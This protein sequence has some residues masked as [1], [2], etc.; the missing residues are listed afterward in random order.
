MSKRINFRNGISSAL[1][2]SVISAA[3]IGPGTVTTAAKAGAEFGLSL[4]W[5]LVFSTFATIILQEAAAR[6]TIASGKNLGQIIALKYSQ[7]SSKYLHW[8]LFLAV[9]F[10]CAAYEAG[11]ILGATEG[12]KLISPLQRV[13]TLLVLSIFSAVLLW[14]GNIKLISHL[15]GWMVALM[16]VAFIGVA[17]QTEKTFIEFITYSLL[18]SLPAGSGLLVIGLIGTTIVPYNF[19]LGSGITQGQSII[20]MRWGIALAVSIGGLI[21]MAILVAGIGINTEF[22]YEAVINTLQSTYGRWASMLFGFGLFA[23]GLSSAIT[24]PLAAA[25]TAKSLLAS[26]GT[27]SWEPNSFQYRIV[28]G[29]V[30][31]IGFIFGLAD[32]KPIPVIILAQALNGILLPLVAVFLLLAVNDQKL[33]GPVYTNGIIANLASTFIVGVACFIGLNNLLKSLGVAIGL[34]IPV[35]FALAGSIT[36]MLWL[37]LKIRA[38]KQ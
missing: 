2:W 18:P 28:W 34:Q 17:F 25:I 37:M 22:S 23:A 9:A 21:S 15:L 32:F 16:G 5:A 1:F 4:L 27:K 10:G 33:L 31:F 30:L 24:A 38:S 7:T 3:F 26:S 29:L 19:F 20:E 14:V 6:I 36:L 13:P 35:Y 12:L 8:V 11:N